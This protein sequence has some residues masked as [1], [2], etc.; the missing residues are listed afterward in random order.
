MGYHDYLI[1]GAGL[2]RAWFAHEMTIH[3]KLCMVRDRRDCLAGSIYAKK[4]L[5]KKHK[6]G[7]HIYT[8]DRDVWEYALKGEKKAIFGRRLGKFFITTWIR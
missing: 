1:M 8:R 2:Y 4:V 6:Y 5:G 7:T 3:G